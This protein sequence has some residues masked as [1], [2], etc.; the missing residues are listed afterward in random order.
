MKSRLGKIEEVRLPYVAVAR[1]SEVPPGK[2]I[3][4]RVDGRPIAVFNVG[5]EFRAVDGACPHRGAALWQ[6]FVDDGI[7]T[8]P[9]HGYRFELATGDSVM[10][11]GFEVGCYGV[12]VRDEVVEVEIA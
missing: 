10:P 7:V 8:C 5:G 9:L 2:S 6:G 3:G 4:V 11:P 12:R 1:A